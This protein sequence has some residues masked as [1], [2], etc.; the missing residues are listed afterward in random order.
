MA[1]SKV[2]I[3]ILI[4]ACAVQPAGSAALTDRDWR[5]VEL[6]GAPSIPSSGDGQP[7]L[8]FNT[9]ESRMEGYSGCNSF[10]GTYQRS[11]TS[12]RIPGPVM[13][14]KRACVQRELNSQESRFTGTFDAIDRY[15]IEGRVLTLLSGDTALARLEAVNE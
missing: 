4:A 7:F 2:A 15:A 3:L 14:T 12:L 10:S 11:G 1:W 5:L 13:M 6:R 9:A 8:R